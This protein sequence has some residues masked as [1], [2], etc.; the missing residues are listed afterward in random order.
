MG[1]MCTSGTSQK[2][3]SSAFQSVL[4]RK[5]PW[6]HAHIRNMPHSR[7]VLRRCHRVYCPRVPYHDI[8][9]QKRRLHSDTRFE[10]TFVVA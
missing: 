3:R 7:G 4:A 9:S 1:P 2:R 5:V 10:Y 6:D 8:S